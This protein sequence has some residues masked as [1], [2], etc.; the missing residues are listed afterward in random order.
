MRP[1]SC[2]AP[3]CA[4][5]GFWWIRLPSVD[6]HARRSAK[7]FPKIP[8]YL[9]RR[10]VTVLLLIAATSGLVFNAFTLLVPKLMQERLASDPSLMPLAGVAAHRG[11]AVRR[12]RPSS[13]SDG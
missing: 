4:L 11:N 12:G 7:P 6:T 8:A 3:P 10:A 2:P 9:V 13:R 1:S 5:L